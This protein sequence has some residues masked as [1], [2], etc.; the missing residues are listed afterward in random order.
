MKKIE[1]KLSFVAQ[2][3]D[4]FVCPICR[5]SFTDTQCYSVICENGHS[6]DFSKKG[7][8][9][10][11]TH[12]I[13]S[14][15][16]DDRMWNSRAKIQAAGFFEPIAERI[17]SLIGS[18]E[19]Q[20]ILD[21]GCGEGSTLSYIERKR[22]SSKDVMIGFDISKK[23]INLAARR[24]TDVF[25]CIAD[26]AQLPFKKGA[27]DIIID[28]FS[29]SA[30]SEFNRVLA[31]GGSL[32]KIIPNS[33]YLIEL[34]HLLYDQDN[35]N[36]SYNNQDVL[37]LFREKYPT[38]RI[39]QL[40]YTFELTPALFEYLVYMTPLHWGADS[41]RLNQVLSNGLSQITIDVSVLFIK[42]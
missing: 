9:Y 39:E 15:Y 42:S 25:Y 26:L 38:V 18:K 31:H 2:N 19:K 13:T 8:L 37:E 34:R 30:Y 27:F 41:E 5:A 24:E 23:A 12:Q 29:P 1:K 10:F 32:I 36:Y 16:D 4:M 21:V 14:D 33:N 11:L 20:R 28:M 3:I 40:K 35:K 17:T 6:F 22:Q 7:T